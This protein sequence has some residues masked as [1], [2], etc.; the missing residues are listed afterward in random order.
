MKSSYIVALFLIACVLADPP[1]P[2]WGG[3]PVWTTK[4]RSMSKNSSNPESS[5]MT[6]QY[7]YNWNV[8]G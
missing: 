1:T 8:K 3:N 2:F 7:F 4:I 5:N 6:A